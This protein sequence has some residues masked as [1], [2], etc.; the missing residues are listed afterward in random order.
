MGLNILGSSLFKFIF[1][2]V[3]C[4]IKSFLRYY[5]V[6]V[7][8]QVK[9]DAT[10]MGIDVTS[11]QGLLF[12]NLRGGRSI[13]AREVGFQYISERARWSEIIKAGAAVR[14]CHGENSARA[15]YLCTTLEE[16]YRVRQV[17]EIMG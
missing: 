17:L 1:P 5:I 15:Q 12:E 9:S 11:A 13:T 3:K 10:A 14:Q 7:I 6:W 4:L 2:V 8:V 16:T